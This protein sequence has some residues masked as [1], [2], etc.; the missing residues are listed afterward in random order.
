MISARYENTLL[1][2]NLSQR[3]QDLIF[4][5]LLRDIHLN[6]WIYVLFKYFALNPYTYLKREGKKTYENLTLYPSLFSKFKINNFLVFFLIAKF[7]SSSYF[8]FVSIIIIT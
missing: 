5:L 1:K 8:S 3:K 4:F 7:F 2:K 6:D